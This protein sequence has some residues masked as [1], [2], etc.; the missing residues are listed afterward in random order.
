MED[1]GVG[2]AETSEEEVEDPNIGDLEAEAVGGLEPLV[3][4]QLEGLADREE[5]GAN[6]GEVWH[7]RR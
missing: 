1:A 3:V 2:A 4:E 7:P 5:R 6:L